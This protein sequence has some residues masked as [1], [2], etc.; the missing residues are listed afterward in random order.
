MCRRNRNRPHVGI[1]GSFEKTLWAFL[2]AG[3][4]AGTLEA[5]VSL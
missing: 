1:L 2:L 5:M 4:L 3:M